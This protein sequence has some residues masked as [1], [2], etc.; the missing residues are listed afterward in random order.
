M[1]ATRIAALGVATLLLLAV[2]V[3]TWATQPKR[4]EVRGVIVSL[5]MGE[6]SILV[7]QSRPGEDRFW[8][9]KRHG[10]TR[11]EIGGRSARF[12]RLRLG[13][14]VEVEGRLT[15]SRAILADE[16]E[17]VG[18]EPKVAPPVILRPPTS[19]IPVPSFPDI[20]QVITTPPQ[21]LRP[22][23]GA[24]ISASEFAIVGR[25]VPQ[26]QVHIRVATRYI[27]F[28]LPAAGADVTTDAR[29][30]FTH[31]VRPVVRLTGASYQI[32]VKAKLYGLESPPASITVYQR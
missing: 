11:V 18:H 24:Q 9:V 15:A 17:V 20:V 13:D 26:A 31:T 10:R 5:H 3:P 27:V 32:T 19:Q 23:N 6:N 7:R 2:T 29:G 22:A 1:G 14:T 28:D 8:V 16:I 30:V 12:Q 25:T 21:I 4:V